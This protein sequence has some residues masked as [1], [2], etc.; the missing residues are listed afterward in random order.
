MTIPADLIAR[1]ARDANCARWRVTPERFADALRASAERGLPAIARGNPRELA[2]YLGGLRLEDLALAC[3][4]ADGNDDA[5]EHFVRE[6]RPGLYRAADAIDPGGSARELADSLYA[7]LFGLKEAGGARVSLFR[8]FHGRSSMATWLRA[9]LA[10]RH[11]DRLRERQRTAPLPEEDSPAAVP[12]PAREPDGDRDRDVAA[13]HA[14]LTHAV[15]SLPPADRIRL[16]G[17]YTQGLTL[18]ELARLFKEHEATASRHLTRIR[19]DIRTAIERHLRAAGVPDAAIL[20]CLQSAAEDPGPIDLGAMLRE[21][22]TG[23]LTDAQRKKTLPD[24]SPQEK[25][26]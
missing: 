11:V 3:A 19:R 14:A 6:Q 12:A 21:T 24:R 7:D 5:W 8:Y 18:A 15:A 25:T 4:C 22:G 1:L 17:Y 16:G 13:V 9:V 10:R 23:P 2:R 26:L 20:R